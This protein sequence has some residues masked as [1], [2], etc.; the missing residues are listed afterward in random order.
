M[1]QTG[2]ST[3]ITALVLMAVA[4]AAFAAWQDY[5]SNPVFSPPGGAYYPSVLH[6][7]ANFSGHGAAYPYKMWYDAHDPYSPALA[8]SFDGITWTVLANPLVGLKTSGANQS[9]NHLVVRYDAGGFGGSGY[10]YRIWYWDM[11]GS[12]SVP[13]TP[14]EL[15][16][17]QTG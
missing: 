14:S 10:F 8:G 6:D 9:A 16:S 3:L 17:R 15:P 1:R 4:S 2:W 13:S 5:G 11:D 12:H 7:A